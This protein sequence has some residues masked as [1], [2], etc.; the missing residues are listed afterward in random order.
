M[1]IL[2]CRL[3]SIRLTNKIHFALQPD[4]LMARVLLGVCLLTS[5]SVIILAAPREV[6]GDEVKTATKSAPES[7]TE[8]VGVNL[9]ENIRLRR[10]LDEY[11]RTVDPAHVQIEERRRVMRKRLQ[12]RF[13]TCDRDD[14]GALVLDEIFD[15]MP[16][17][18]RRF[19]EVDLN[20]D[21]FITLEE[22]EA[23]Q[24]KMA[25]RQKVIAIKSETTQDADSGP[26]RKG[27]DSGNSNR[28]S[29]L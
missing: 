17:V 8:P 13:A 2:G 24:A 12:E 14:D 5:T 21:R 26:K 22:L 20:S 23:L 18:A 3:N 25:D 11:S 16:Q 28:K 7:K 6:Q 19:A 15:C 27:K 1:I 10:D 29:A 4:S 9:D